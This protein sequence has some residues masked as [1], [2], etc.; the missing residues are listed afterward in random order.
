[1]LRI[2]PAEGL[3]ALPEKTLRL[4]G[5]LKFVLFSTLKAAARNS[6][7]ILSL[8]DVVLSKDTSRS[9]KPGPIK[10]FFPTFPNVPAGS[11]L[12][13]LGLNHWFGVPSMTGPEKA[14]F[15][16]GRSGSPVFPSP[17]R[18]L[19]VRGENAKPLSAVRIE[20]SCQPLITLDRAPLKEFKN[21][22]FF[23]NGSSYSPL[24]TS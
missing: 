19:P 11:K 14:G 10:T 20:L 16:L 2:T 15:Q 12:K 4:P 18:L 8:M 23:P 22:L 6:S 21:G 5:K 24:R 7:P 9:R 1:M 3:I 13:A 17:D